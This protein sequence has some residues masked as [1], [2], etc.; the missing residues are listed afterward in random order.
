MRLKVLGCG[1]AAGQTDRNCSGYLVDA[2]ILL[3]CGPGV[4]RALSGSVAELQAIDRILI[5]HFHIDHTADLIPILWARYVLEIGQRQTLALFGPPGT[6]RWFKRLTLVHRDWT[7]ELFVTVREMEGKTVTMDGYAV[8]TRPT[9]HTPNSI[10]Y[11]ITDS[12]HTSI[13]YSGDSAW[14]ADLV[15]PARSCDLAIVEASVPST[16]PAADHL[17]ARLAGALAHRAGVRRL[18][19]THLYPEALKNDP[20][21]E[22][23]REYA[24]EITLAQDGLTIDL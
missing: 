12:A 10:C 14:N 20:L 13:F 19:L 16:N 11:R 5:S 2:R 18:L 9:L 17:S 8:E 7:R 21:G 6:R 4:W 1:T 3:D 22:A 24:G 23:K 15:E